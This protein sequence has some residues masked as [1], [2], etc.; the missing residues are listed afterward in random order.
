MCE[1]EEFKIDTTSQN[2]FTMNGLNPGVI[3]RWVK[4]D[5]PGDPSPE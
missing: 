4:R 5:R 1:D 3:Y 2:I